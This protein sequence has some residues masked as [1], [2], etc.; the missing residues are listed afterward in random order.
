MSVDDLSWDTTLGALYQMVRWVLDNLQL[1]NI[2]DVDLLT[3]LAD[4]HLTQHQLLDAR[5]FWPRNDDPHYYAERV[6][7]FG[8]IACSVC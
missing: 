7:F 6:F 5:G 8:W 1:H 2:Y 4:A 3:Q